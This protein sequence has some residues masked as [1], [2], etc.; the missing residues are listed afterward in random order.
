MAFADPQS[1][2][3]NAI[4]NSLPRVSQGNY[5]G[6]FMTEDGL[7]TLSISHEKKKRTR[8]L[9]KITQTKTVTD[10]LIPANSTP[11]SISAY[12]VVDTP[13]FGYTAAE[14]KLFVAGL[15]K[16]LTDSSGAAVTKLLGYES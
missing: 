14:Q 1:V 8:H 7:L 5:N 10:P 2:T 6:A 4:A 11:V 13:P 12:V 16:F 9:L 3:I 15:T